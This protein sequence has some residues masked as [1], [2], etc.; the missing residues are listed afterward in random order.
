MSSILDIQ[1]NTSI[2]DSIKSYE[3]FSFLPITGTNLNNANA[4][5]IRIENSDCFYRPC[6]SEIQFEGVITKSAAGHERY[7]KADITSLSN[8]GLMYL[9]DNIK[10]ELSNTE[11]GCL[12]QPG[13][14][15]TMMGLLTNPESY[16]SGGGLNSGWCMDTGDGAASLTTNTGFKARNQA[17]F[18]NNVVTAHAEDPNAGDFR[19]SMKLSDI[20]G[21]ADDYKKVV[22]G[23]VHTLTLIRN[24]NDK[25]ALFKAVALEAPGTVQF[26]KIA[27]VVPIVEPS[28]VARYEM[29]KLIKEQLV[30]TINYRMR[31]CLTTTVPP[32]NAFTWR[33]GLRMAPQKPRYLII[34]FQTKRVDD[35]DKN[36]SAFDNCDLTNAY[37]LLNN[38]RYPALDY[39]ASF[40]KNHYENL[41]R[42]FYQFTEKYYGIND[43]VS[44]TA[45]NPIQY[46][47]L[48]PL[49]VFDVSKQSEKIQQA[50]VDITIQ[51]FFGTN[52]A[53]G[54]TAYCLMISDQRVKFKS[55]GNKMNLV[56]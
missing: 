51:C 39:N 47:H 9:F 17:I 3:R 24:M 27:W 19:I 23:F 22:Y 37:A 12:Y 6:D 10:Y 31:Q 30:L 52:V 38:V 1:E 28:E 43:S 26:T 44:S 2:D 11:M 15:T 29:L 54:T 41:Y 20:L 25:N 48:Y 18:K 49:I 4:I 53:A 40:K 7:K 33:I 32:I 34:S 8:N 55:D 35:E 16:N 36:L 50:V 14:A 21:F 56:Y 45:V 42:D 46:K 5:V 13:Q